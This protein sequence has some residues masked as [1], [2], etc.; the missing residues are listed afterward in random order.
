VLL[1]LGEPDYD[2]H[3]GRTLVYGWTT[4]KMTYLVAAGG[5]YS[6]AAGA[7]DS[8]INYALLIEFDPAN[9]ITRWETRKAP[10]G[11]SGKKFIEQL[12]VSW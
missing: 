8:P 2:W 4:T 3:D 1:K 11:V 9:R 5:G 12:Q 7:F 6:G 10:F